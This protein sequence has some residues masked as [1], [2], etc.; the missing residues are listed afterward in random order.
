MNKTFQDILDGLRFQPART[1]LALFAVSL[2][3]MALTALLAVAGGLRERSRALS[4][5][6]GSQ[7]F[8][9]LPGGDRNSRLDR[10]DRDRL[11]AALPGLSVSAVRRSTVGE[12]GGR[13]RWTV[14]GVD[15]SLAAIRDW[16]RLRGRFIDERDVRDRARVAVVTAGTRP[17][18]TGGEIA[19]G[20][21]PFSVVG[22]VEAGPAL[23]DMRLAEGFPL[24]GESTVL[25]PYTAALPIEGGAAADRVDA[26]LIHAG[27]IAN[28]ERAIE[29]ARRI[30]GQERPA[31]AFQWVTAESAIEGLRRLNALITA[32]VGAVAILCLVLGG[33]TLVS[34]MV[35]NVRDRIPEIGLRRALGARP[36]DV[37][38][39]FVGE[40]CLVTG[41]AA[42]LGTA[43]AH[44]AFAAVG[45]RCPVP[46]HTGAATAVVPVVTAILLGGLFA[47]WPARLAARIQPA[48][49]LRSE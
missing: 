21:M 14:V 12:S 43:A 5:A 35:A 42:L 22:D 39:L 40:S 31:A 19:L 8:A 47:F 7:V 23:P 1:C 49:A 20:G 41:G 44:A 38:L 25:V 16:R 17:R 15:G 30:L 18:E 48:D 10:R 34:L 24:F 11:A 36:A 33:T 6:M 3:M 4:E 46:L 27:E 37:A 32:A 13:E 26:V 29:S 28:F 9:I 2:G 45:S